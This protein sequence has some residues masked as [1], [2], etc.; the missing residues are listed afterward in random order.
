M[1]FANPS[2]LETYRFLKESASNT[3]N[4][5]GLNTLEMGKKREG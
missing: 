2:L 5:V 4:I 1:K 3:P